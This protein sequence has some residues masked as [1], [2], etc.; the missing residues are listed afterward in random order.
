MKKTK[1]SKKLL[2]LVFIISVLSGSVLI[3]SIMLINITKT[4]ESL[5]KSL[6]IKT[7]SNSQIELDKYFHTLISNLY[8][9]R[10]LCNQGVFDAINNENINTY[11]IPAFNNIPQLNTVVVADTLGNEYSIIREDSTWLSNIVYESQDSGI[12]IIRDRWQGDVLNKT[13]IDEWVDY[14]SNYDPRTRPWYLGAMNT[15]SPDIV[16]WT[17]PYLFYTYQLPG[18]TISLRS[19]CPV[20]EKYHVIQ[21]DILLSHISKFTTNEK[22][23][24]NGKTFILSEEYKVIGLPKEDFLT[25]IDSIKKYILKDYDSINSKAMEFAV[26]KWKTFSANYAEPFSFRYNNEKWWAKISKYD[27]GINNSFL[28]GVIVPENDFVEEIHKTRNVVISGFAIVLLFI[29]L[30]IRQ[31]ILRRKTNVILTNQKL[32][33]EL[34]RDKIEEHHKTVLF[35]KQEITDSINYAQQIQQ[36][37]LPVEKILKKT[38]SE[39]FI[40]LKPQHIVSGDFYWM[41]K[42]NNKVII[43]AADCTGHGVPGAFMSMLGIAFL[44]EIVREDSDLE[45]NEILDTLR[46]YI[47]I[48]LK[49]NVDL[50]TSKDGMDMALYII[51]KNLMLQYSG[52]YNP[53]FLIFE[54]KLAE[55]RIDKLKDNKK[56][57]LYTPNE[58]NSNSIIEIKADRQPVGIYSYEKKFTNFDIQLQKGDVLYTFSDGFQDQFGGEKGKK[59]MVRN[60]KKLFLKIHKKPMTEQKQILNKTIVDWHKGYKQIDDILIIGVRI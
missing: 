25:N 26:N 2:F 49:Q 56:C 34:Q 23:S 3:L 52:A 44:N 59:F 48:S 55:K 57:K 15:E 42:S 32:E 31:N 33:I 4:A 16:W 20:T 29:I 53:L 36:A 18:I 12:V 41:K 28:I 6:I 60:L 5:A 54:E 27:L 1:K 22:I 13:S 14:N 11:I 46:E 10:D 30:V 45:A 38:F 40:I 17:N 9:G 51:D 7:T 50:A 39:H 21:Y 43:V 8:V 35:Q 37:L 24:K 47:K 19:Y 58:E